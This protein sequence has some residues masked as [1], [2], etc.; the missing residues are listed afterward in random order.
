MGNRFWSSSANLMCRKRESLD[1]STEP[2]QMLVWWGDDADIQV[3]LRVGG[4]W[5]IIRWEDDVER[6]SLL[7]YT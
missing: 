4:R 3:D 5:T 6:P 2:E 1:T 7:R